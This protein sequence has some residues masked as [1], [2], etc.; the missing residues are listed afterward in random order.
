MLQPASHEPELIH[1][2]GMLLAAGAQSLLPLPLEEARMSEAVVATA[3]DGHGAPSAAAPKRHVRG[4]SLHDV[5]MSMAPP[6]GEL[7]ALD[8][9]SFPSNQTARPHHHSLPSPR[10]ELERERARLER[11][12]ER[13]RHDHAHMRVWVAHRFLHLQSHINSLCIE[14]NKLQRRAIAEAEE[15]EQEHEREIARVMGA[16]PNTISRRLAE[17]RCHSSEQ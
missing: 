4:T 6:S 5:L 17:M 8:A 10:A 15:E 2:T 11:L 13:E 3:A 1:S 7:L 16:T 14:R 12:L 9:Q